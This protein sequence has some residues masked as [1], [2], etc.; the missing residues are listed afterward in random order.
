MRRTTLAGR[1]YFKD[2]LNPVANTPPDTRSSLPSGEQN[3]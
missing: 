1:E 3:A 2:I